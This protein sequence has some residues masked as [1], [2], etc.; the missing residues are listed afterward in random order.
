MKREFLKELGLTDEQIDRVMAENGKDIEK[1]KSDLETKEKELETKETELETLQGQ[2]EA[3]NKQIEDFKEMDIEGIK[4]AADDY[5]E[6]YEKAKQDAEAEIEAL[7][8]EHSLESA[9]TK[10]GAKNV[11]AVKALLDIESLRNSKNV[12]SDLETAITTLKETDSYL[13]GDVEPEGTGGSLGNNP[14]QNQKVAITKEDFKNM[15]Y[16]ERLELKRENENLYNQLI[17]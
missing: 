10:A 14:R 8:F 13:F 7:K 15:G 9:L 3:A 12:D 2:L 1:Y 5:K 16:K 4:Q 6:K 17:E 11:K